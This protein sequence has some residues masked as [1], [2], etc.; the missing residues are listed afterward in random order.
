MRLIRPFDRRA[1]LGEIERKDIVRIWRHNEHGV[2][3]HDR[4]RFLPVVDAGRE[5]KGDLELAHFRAVNFVERRISCGCIVLCRHRPL[6]V[7]GR[8]R[9]GRHSRHLCCG[10]CRVKQERCACEEQPK[11]SGRSYGSRQTRHLVSTNRLRYRDC[12]H[13]KTPPT[14]VCYSSR[15]GFP[16]PRRYDDAATTASATAWSC[17]PLPLT[18]TAP[19]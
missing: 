8:R 12:H 11:P 2:V 13:W 6:T 16:S 19:T 14:S 17:S 1:G 18:P 15:R 9:G 10:Q 7:L 5:G 4:R 3:G